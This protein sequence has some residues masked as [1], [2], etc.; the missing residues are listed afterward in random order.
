MKVQGQVHRL[1]CIASNA[2]FG[3]TGTGC[4]SVSNLKTVQRHFS[5]SSSSW[6]VVLIHCNPEINIS[7]REKMRGREMLIRVFWGIINI[8]KA[9]WASLMEEV[10]EGKLLFFLIIIIN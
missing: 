6:F 2:A 1:F 4:N 3:F 10:I 5:P 7:Y 8:C 9:L